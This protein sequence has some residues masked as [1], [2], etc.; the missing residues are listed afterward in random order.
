MTHFA[1]HRFFILYL[2]QMLSRM[3]MSPMTQARFELVNFWTTRP[4]PCQDAIL[5][6]RLKCAHVLSLTEPE[7]SIFVSIK[8]QCMLTSVTGKIIP[9]TSHELYRYTVPTVTGRNSDLLFASSFLN[10]RQ[11]LAVWSDVFSPREVR[12][13]CAVIRWGVGAACFPARSCIT[14]QSDSQPL[15]HLCSISAPP[16][17]AD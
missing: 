2:D 17:C 16:A 5:P 11:G 1:L 9:P 6:P 12:A 7:Q 4:R 15:Q 8:V 13:H 14:A 3:K 10:S